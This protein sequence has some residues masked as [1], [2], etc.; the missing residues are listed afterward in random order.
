MPFQCNI[1][2]GCFYCGKQYLK[3]NRDCN[4]AVLSH[5]EL[6]ASAWQWGWGSVRMLSVAL[7]SPHSSSFRSWRLVCN[8]RL[9]LVF[10]SITLR[11]LFCAGLSRAALYS[12]SLFASLYP[13]GASGWIHSIFLTFSFKITSNLLT[14]VI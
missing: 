5:G 3:G 4:R 7:L 11:W 8:L 1:F 6:E 2:K 14:H 12:Q 13:N 10:V 9:T